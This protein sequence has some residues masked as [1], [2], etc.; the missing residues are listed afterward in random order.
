MEQ[1]TKLQTAV[2]TGFY[3]TSGSQVVLKSVSFPDA[4]NGTVVGLLAESSIL[5]TAEQIGLSK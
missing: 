5:Q 2:Q 4:N 1:S 3:N